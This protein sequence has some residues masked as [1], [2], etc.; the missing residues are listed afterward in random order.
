[1]P[2]ERLPYRSVAALLA[3]V[4]VAPEDPATQA[5][6]DRLRDVGRRRE[7]TRAE[8]L[9]MA[10]WKSARATPHYRRNTAA[11]VR[12]ASRRALAARTERRR[13]EALTSLSG[14]SVPVASA[15]LTLIDP[16]RYGVLD[17]RVWQLLHA[18]G[19]V[20]AKPSGRGFGPADWERYLDCLRPAAR[21]RR[22]TVRAV[23]FT[24]FHC[25]RRFQAGRLYDPVGRR[26]GPRPR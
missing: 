26:A 5:L 22:V 4:P 14:V 7:F 25:H 9:V 3:R 23:E 20:D 11:R 15:I 13:L 8:F 16:A 6:I 21:R 19:A 18:L 24:L 1:V 2:V 12:R 17:I 10:R